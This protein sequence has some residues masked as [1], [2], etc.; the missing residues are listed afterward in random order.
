MFD[1]LVEAIVEMREQET[2][3][4]V[5]DLLSDNQDPLKILDASSLAMEKIGTRFEEGEYFLPE[6]IMAGELLRQISEI[7]KPKL[8]G[9]QVQAS[10]KLGK[11][12]LGTVQGDIHNVGKDI[13]AF[14]LEI[15]G[16]DVR[17]LGTDVPPARFVEAIIDYQPQVLGMSG[18]LTLAYE[19]MKQTVQAVGDAGLRENVKIMIGG[20]QT[21]DKIR[22]HVGADAYGNNAMAAVR[23]V[24]KWTGVE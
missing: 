14:M 7:I 3:E 17:D 11:I 2:L 8:V 9:S 5:K 19:S 10:E 6:L 22:E 4:T 20:G 21:S 15:N 13:V 16:F 18:L 1:K 24:K 23:I 12:L